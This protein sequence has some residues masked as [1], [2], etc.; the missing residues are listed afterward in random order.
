M[1]EEL[2]GKYNE[3]VTLL[4]ELGIIG[5]FAIREDGKMEKG[6]QEGLETRK[7]SLDIFD[8]ERMRDIDFTDPA[9]RE[10][11]MSSIPSHSPA[12][13]NMIR[14]SLLNGM[15]SYKKLSGINHKGDVNTP[16][17]AQSAHF[18]YEG[19]G[20]DYIQQKR[21]GLLR[22]KKNFLKYVAT[23]YELRR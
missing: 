8:R 14:F 4:E 11:L 20:L 2:T 5:R 17:G 22:R 16:L 1:A 6:F 7:A 23:D 21:Q 3:A 15:G 9:D 18:H 10:R 13:A 19:G 12:V